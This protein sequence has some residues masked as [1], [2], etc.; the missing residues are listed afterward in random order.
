MANSVTRQRVANATLLKYASKNRDE[1]F[2]CDVTINAGKQTIAANRLV[3]SCYSRYFEGMF[4]SQMKER[5]E[6]AIEIQAVDGQTTKA[7]IDFIYI[8]SVTINNE[9]VML[10]LSGADY[11]QVQ[12]VKQFCFEY[13]RTNVSPDN[14]LNILKAATMYENDALKNEVEQYISDHF[15]EVAQTGDFK[16]LSKENL[17]A[18]I[19]NLDK[20]KVDT[21]LVY[22]AILF[23]ARHEDYRKADFP[24]LFKMLDLNK[25]SLDFFEEFILEEDLVTSSFDCQ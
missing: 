9:N 20:E 19:S 18:R 17:I 16:S 8:G 12:E 15:D 13:L 21:A 24:Q 5:Y 6:S 25:I 22:N 1:G 7:L 14:A 2:F 10:L 11:F 3:L 4:K 23:W